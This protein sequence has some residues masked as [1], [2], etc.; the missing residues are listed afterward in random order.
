MFEAE[1]KAATLS[2]NLLVIFSIFT[3]L[4]TLFHLAVSGVQV[5][6]QELLGDGDILDSSHGVVTTTVQDDWLWGNIDE[7]ILLLETVPRP[8][9]PRVWRCIFTLEESSNLTKLLKVASLVV[10]VS[11]GLKYIPRL[12]NS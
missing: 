10:L 3:I 1:R 9:L 11:L 6:V 5:Q 8:N 4:Q 2:Y 7:K 12:S